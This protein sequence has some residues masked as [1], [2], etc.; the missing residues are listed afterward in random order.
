MSVLKE[1]TLQHYS[2]AAAEAIITDNT[3]GLNPTHEA[4]MDGIR[5]RLKVAAD[6]VPEI[7]SA[8]MEQGELV[9]Y[10]DGGVRYTTLP[11]LVPDVLAPPPDDMP[12]TAEEQKIS[13]RLFDELLPLQAADAK[14]PLS[15]VLHVLE[16]E[17]HGPTRPNRLL[18]QRLGR[19]GLLDIGL[20]ERRG[21]GQYRHIKW[22]PGVREQW[23]FHPEDIQRDLATGFYVPPPQDELGGR[24]HA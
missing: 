16:R 13:G 18:A 10:D 6:M 3:S 9:S 17:G 20:S 1:S 11:G 22:Q 15:E 23:R 12:L 21:R 14:R 19:R 4:F 5:R 2:N 24:H 8:L 7:V